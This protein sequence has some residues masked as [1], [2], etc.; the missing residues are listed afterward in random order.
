MAGDYGESDY[1]AGELKILNVPRKPAAQTTAVDRAQGIGLLPA[2]S[3]PQGLQSQA[4]RAAAARP[5]NE[6]FALA[7][8]PAQRA[9]QI[10][11][12]NEA[13]HGD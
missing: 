7:L 13:A 3:V 2:Q 12:F 5:V 10:R 4:L 11:Y 9:L 8:G 1:V 6:P